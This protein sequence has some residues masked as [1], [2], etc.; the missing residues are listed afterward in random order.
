MISKSRV[1]TLLALFTICFFIDSVQTHSHGS[2][3]NNPG[4]REG[5]PIPGGPIGPVGPIAPVVLPQQMIQPVIIPFRRIPREPVYQ[6]NQYGYDQDQY[7]EDEEDRDGY[8]YETN[9][10]Y[11]QNKRPAYRNR[12]G[13]RSG[14]SGQMYRGKR[15]HRRAYQDDSDSDSK[16]KRKH[17]RRRGRYA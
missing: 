8:A 11:N 4:D 9:N 6:Y 13:L 5:G 10:N 3:S 16:F 12:N 7:S 15:H 14:R 1:T 2:Y 17:K